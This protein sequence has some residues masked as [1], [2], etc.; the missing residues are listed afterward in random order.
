MIFGDIRVILFDAVGTLLLPEPR[1]AVVY[2]AV[3]ARFG[4]RL[5]VAE[6]SRRFAA[7]FARQEAID[8]EAGWRTSEEREVQRWRVLVGSVLDDVEDGEAC[9]QVLFQH[10]AEPSGWRCRPGTAGVLLE[11]ARRGYVLGLASNYDHRLRSVAAGLE[12]LQSIRH[13]FISSEIGWR[14]PG[15]E[16]YSV[17]SAALEVP[18]DKI[19]MVGDDLDNDFHG[20]RAAGFQALLYDPDEAH[21]DVIPRIRSL[22]DLR[23]CLNEPPLHPFR[24]L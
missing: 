14:K 9:F 22:E 6:V 16:F 1:A 8:R 5:G 19:L 24:P 20:A 11:L 18:P 10:F 2:A 21:A 13:L 17:T 4:S 23:L 12:E 3:G 7:A 15:R